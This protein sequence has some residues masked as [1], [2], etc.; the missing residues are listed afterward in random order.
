MT[1]PGFGGE[2]CVESV[3]RKVTDL[4]LGI[5]FIRRRRLVSLCYTMIFRKNGA[6]HC[7]FWDFFK[8]ILTVPNLHLNDCYFMVIIIQSP[9]SE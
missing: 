3:C 9:G 4:F 7:F 2:E 1:A 6:P 5:I 8:H